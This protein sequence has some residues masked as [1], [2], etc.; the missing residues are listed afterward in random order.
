M[1]D[2]TD[3]KKIE[4]ILINVEKPARYTGGE[5]NSYTKNKKDIN[6]RFLFAFPDV[7]EIGMSHLG[8]HILYNML[9]EKED[10]WCERVFAPWTDME[11]EL[12]N[13]DLELFA[14]ESWDSIKD[15]DIIGFTL[16]YEMSYT[17][18]LNMLDLG[19]I[20]IKSKDRNDS[21][22]LIISGGPCA[23]NPEPLHEFIDLFV[24]GEGEEVTIEISNLL[25]NMKKNGSYT[26]DKF[27]KEA[28]KIEGIYIPSFYEEKYKENGLISERV[29][30]KDDAKP[31]VKKRIIKDLNSSF[32]PDKTIVP[33]IETVHDRVIV[34][35]FRGCTRGC[36]FCQ[37][38]MIYRPVREK[39]KETIIKQGQALLENTGHEEISLSSLSSGD[40]SDIDSLVIELLDKYEKD[41]INVALPS[42]RMDSL[43]DELIDR[44][45]SVRKSSITFAPEAGTQR[46]RDIINKNISE[47][48]VTG[49]LKELFD[50][51]WSSVKL[52]F[53]IGL[54]GEEKDDVL[55]IKE[56]AY[57]IKD[58]FFKRPKEEI[59]GNF[60]LTTSV[61]CFVPKAFTPFQ[62]EAQNDVEEFYDKI[63]LL[64]NNIKDKKITYNYHEPERSYLEGVFARGDRKLSKVLETAWKKGCKFDGWDDKFK[65]NEWLEAFLDVNIDP[66]FYTV[67][68]RDFDEILPWD[69]IDS[70]V[71]KEFL[72]KEKM[73]SENE[74]V[75][76][77]CKMLCHNCGVNT[78]IMKGSCYE[79]N[80]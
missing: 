8:M 21:D 44:I 72:I 6:L 37:A 24:I 53:M 50:L 74:D 33:Y 40:Y 41:N 39:D 20:P 59:R 42:L 55:G 18:I 48:D 5:L 71:K 73:K 75:T 34:E 29:A 46:M 31:I 63:N 76:S 67:R 11:E 7:Y 30:I 62:W 4:K 36:R 19:K 16:Q 60:K 47:E 17:N 1:N 65:F 78:G 23:Y 28:S 10:I 25:K 79:S 49:K 61:S 64:K 54:P 38:G 52:Y 13:N 26:K 27:L 9:N 70:G 22:P 43:S 15:F 77:D 80:S 2:M 35:I 51:G 69:F 12:K 56:L 68:K 66:D 58:L 45:Q 57:K 14:I 32:Y 3:T